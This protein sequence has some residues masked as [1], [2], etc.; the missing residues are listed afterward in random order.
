MY[1]LHD[2]ARMISDEIRIDAYA[3]A[4]ESAVRPGSVVVDIGTGTGIFALIACRLGARRVYAIDPSE[5]IA[6]G[7]ELALENGFAEPIHFIQDD[8]RRVR[9]PERADVVISDLR[10]G[11]PFGPANLAVLA[12][13]REHVLAP[14]GTLIPQRDTLMVAVVESRTRYEHAL[15]RVSAH[16]ITLRTMRTRLANSVHKDRTRSIRPSD[17]LTPGATWGTLEY[18]TAIAQPF[19]GKAAWRAEREGLGHGLLVWF[20]ALL[21]GGHGFST[22]PGLDVVYP[23]LFLPWTEPVP[24]APGDR[25]E[26]QLWAQPEGDSW[27]WNTDVTRADGSDRA[28]FKQATFLAEVSAPRAHQRKAS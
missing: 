3:R 7:R 17:L 12:H 13:A 23:Q 11:M 21:A 15:G 24:I 27:G 8:V 20:D 10:G 26:V 14:G 9:L 25:I 1:G 5:A 22:G 6:V 16:G 2:F 18:A 4:L 28:R 19:S